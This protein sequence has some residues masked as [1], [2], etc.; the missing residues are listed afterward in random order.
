MTFELDHDQSQKKQIKRL[1]NLRMKAFRWKRNT[2]S[3]SY[4]IYGQTVQASH[5]GR[6]A[7]FKT[8]DNSC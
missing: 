6:A 7:N 3:T 5:P 4:Y 8:L 1:P 2:T